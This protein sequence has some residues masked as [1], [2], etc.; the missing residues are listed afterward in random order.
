M[1]G[2]AAVTGATGFI[3][4]PLLRALNRNTWKVRALTRKPQADENNLE[5]IIG[6]L[7][8]KQA[9]H[10]LVNN[11]DVIIHCAGQVRGNSLKQFLQSNSEGTENLV[12]VAIT[13]NKKPRFL[14]ISSL[15]AR[16]SQL[17]WYANSK[18]LGEQALK[19]LGDQLAW[20]IFRPTAVY[21]PGDREMAPLFKITRFGL[22][23]MVGEAN[24]KFGLIYVDDLIQAIIDWLN[25]PQTKHKIYELDDGS[26][27]GYD[28]YLVKSI[29]S[30]V[31][32]HPVFIVSVPIMLLRCVA[33]INLALSQ[34]FHYLPMLTPGKVKELT[35]HDWVC[36]NISLTEDTD[37]HP[38][39]T[40]QEGLS[41]AVIPYKAE[42]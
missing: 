34:I 41:K 36:N 2:I 15:A 11:V 37:W 31:W 1:P 19:S 13:Q 30:K 9:L 7:Q 25:S 40:L 27:G 42:N 32:G 5:W 22:L 16:E 14:F 17:S 28:R 29:A 12:K 24:S 18:Y 4:K 3:G 20:S 39:V 26:T 35:H 6:D 38:K 33:A 8:N 10:A 21:G 23:P